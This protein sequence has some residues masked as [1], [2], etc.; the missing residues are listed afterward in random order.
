[1]TLPVRFMLPEKIKYPFPAGKLIMKLPFVIT[2][3]EGL[4]NIAALGELGV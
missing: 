3:C 2:F 1:M 4:G